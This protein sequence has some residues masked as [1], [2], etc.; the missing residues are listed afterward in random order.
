MTREWVKFHNSGRAVMK[1]HR[2]I[3]HT[4]PATRLLTIASVT[5]VCLA[6]LGT[7]APAGAATNFSYFFTSGT[8]AIKAGSNTWDLQVSLIG[9]S[10][11]G[12]VTIGVSIETPHLSGNELHNWSMQMPGAD[13]TV[14]S[15]TGAASID[16]HSDL[17]PVATLSLTFKP[18]SHAKGTCSSGSQTDYSGTL[19]GSVT[20][21]T[22]L[23]GLK[24]SDTK[25]SFSTPNTLQQNAACVP[26][27]ACQFATWGGP[28]P[29]SPKTPIAS[30][31][32]AGPPSKPVQFADVG[33]TVTLS[34]PAGANRQDIAE[35]GAPAPVFNAKAKS[36]SVEGGSSGIVTGSA[37]LSK[38]TLIASGSE[39][40]TVDGTKYTE[41]FSEYTAAS[42]ASPAGQQ[43]EGRTIL[44]GT[45]KVKA[46]GKG[47]F[48]IVTLKK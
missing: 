21:N 40:C 20:L 38:T 6:T 46:T 27:L 22:G 2:R 32:T 5:V 11:S 10:G 31:I 28:I 8:V 19:T 29:A 15:S 17:S 16:S 14:D 43:F 7:A 34:A 42:F 39:P 1:V 48:A 23:K 25:A 12:P 44:S 26:P 47:E 45:L 36:L 33:R 35:I 4:G 3:R 24:L 18:T 13:F 30:G 37:V 9:G 41:T